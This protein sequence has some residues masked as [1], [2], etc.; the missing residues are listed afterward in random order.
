MPRRHTLLAPLVLALA[1]CASPATSPSPTEAPSATAEPTLAPTPSPTE[2]PTP[3]PTVAASASVEQL[4]GTWRTTL[5]G[6]TVT[7]RLT[8][9]TYRIHRGTNAGEGEITVD[10]DRIDFFNSSLCPGTG[11][12]RW[13]ITDGD[14]RFRSLTE[15]CP[16]RAEALLNVR[17]GDYSP[18]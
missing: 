11:E 15:P 2:E 7:L 8:P 16:G 14:L 4:F 1:A 9:D 6:T 3:S 17:Y 12:Y 18:P 10:G 5:G 13:S